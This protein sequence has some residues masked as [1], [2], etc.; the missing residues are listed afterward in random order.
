MCF[1]SGLAGAE[2]IG[3]RPKGL[4]QQ[5]ENGKGSDKP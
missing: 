3:R 5:R 2:I 1:H 4:I